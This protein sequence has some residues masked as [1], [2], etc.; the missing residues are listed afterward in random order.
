VLSFFANNTIA[1]FFRSLVLSTFWLFQLIDVEVVKAFSQG[2][3]NLGSRTSDIHNYPTHGIPSELFSAAV[4]QVEDFDDWSDDRKAGLFQFLLRD[5]EV[6][7][8]PLLGCDGV[9]ANKTLQGATWSVGGQLSENDYERKVCLIF[10]DIPVKDLKKFVD[11]FSRIKKQQS[12]MDSLYDLRRFS[13]SLVGNGIG[14]ALILETQNRTETE[15]TQYNLMKKGTP[16]PNE[17]QW[18]AAIEFFVKRSFPGLEDGPVA[19]RFLGSSDV[20]DILSGYWNCICELEAT[21]ANAIVLSYPP[22]T[23]EETLPRF[24][25]VSELI[26]TMNSVYEGEYKYDLVYFHPSYDS[27]KIRSQ[28]EPA[29]GHLSSTSFLREMILKNGDTGATETLTDEQL[30]LQNYRRRSPLPGV[31]IKRVSKDKENGNAQFDYHDVIQLAEEGE[32]KLKETIVAE[33]KLISESE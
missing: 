17:S 32:E 27:D 1:M 24:L 19:Y 2:R 26:N 31:I 15:T 13:L 20:C 5:L 12:L 18:K 4:P 29:N 9:S 21:E 16:A 22:S 11:M 10:E 28:D 3:L 30:K 7:G 6:E 14:P 33:M 23:G 8:V 25:A